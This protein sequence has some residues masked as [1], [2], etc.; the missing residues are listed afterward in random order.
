M[1]R[2]TIHTGNEGR[3]GAFQITISNTG[4]DL[5]TDEEAVE[6]SFWLRPNTMTANHINFPFHAVVASALA[7]ANIAFSFAAC[8]ITVRT[9]GQFTARIDA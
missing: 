2:I 4:A 5:A 1:N 8:S 3:N 6:V 7:D 9:D